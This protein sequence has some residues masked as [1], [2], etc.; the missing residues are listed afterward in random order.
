MPQLDPRRFNLSSIG[1]AYALIESRQAAGK[2]VID[3]AS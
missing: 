2:L 1:A 3:I